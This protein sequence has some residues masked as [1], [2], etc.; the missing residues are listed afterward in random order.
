MAT[1]SPLTPH[2]DS[3][4]LP[5]GTQ[6]FELRYTA[7]GLTA[8]ESNGFRYL[9]YPFDTQW[10][11]AGTERVAHYTNVPPGHYRFLLQAADGTGV[12]GTIKARSSLSVWSRTSIR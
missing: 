8:P 9:L 2:A 3:P 12:R 1:R 4:A 10:T 11:N 7:L 6:R 5:A